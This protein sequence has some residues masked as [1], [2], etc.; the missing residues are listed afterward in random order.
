MDRLSLNLVRVGQAIRALML[1]EA[2]D[3]H[4]TPVQI[5]TLLFVRHTKSFATSISRQALQLGASHAST[6]GVV[7][8]LVA[9][10]YLERSASSKDRRV[11]LLRLTP[12]GE[13]VCDHLGDWRRPL[14][15]LVGQLSSADRQHLERGLA[16]LLTHFE[17]AG[18]AP[19][20]AP[21]DGCRY[22]ARPEAG[23]S[24]ELPYYCNLLQEGISAAEATKDCP[25]FS[26]SVA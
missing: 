11:T 1:R 3:T 9:H 19:A 13:E 12:Q 15:E 4:L 26:P 24:S 14:D 21:C 10:G 5:Q 25:D 17:R 18:I 6:V 20:G 7:D 8:G 2:R 22:L 16:G 23:A